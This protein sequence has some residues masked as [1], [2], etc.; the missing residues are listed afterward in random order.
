MRDFFGY[1]V[2]FVGKFIYK[3]DRKISCERL[4]VEL[5]GKCWVEMKVGICFSFV[6][7]KILL[8]FSI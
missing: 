8:G 1:W 3:I 5:Y 7:E 2:I 6:G 4:L